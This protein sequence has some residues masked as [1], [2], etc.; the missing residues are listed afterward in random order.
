MSR[1]TVFD[2]ADPQ[3]AAPIPKPHE[4][5]AIVIVSFGGPDSSSDVLPFLENVLRGRNVPR[6]RMLEVAEHY[7]KLGGRSPINDQNRALIAA[8]EKEFSTHGIKMPV[9]WG[10]RNW[11]PLLHDTLR[12][13]TADGVQRAL[14]F[15]T[16]AYGSYSSCRQYR[17]DIAAAR[18]EVGPDAPIIDKLRAFFN[19]P[20]FIE[21]MIERTQAA[22]HRIP[23]SRRGN[24]ELIFTA[25]SIP[26]EMAQTSPYESQL[27]LASR[28]VANG[29]GH[30]NWRLVYQ[31]RS[32]PPQQPWLEPDICDYLTKGQAGS[33][34]QDIVVV[35]IGFISDHMEVL[36]DLDTEAR[37]L[38]ERLGINMVRAGT[39]GTHPRFVRMIRELV[40]E[41]TSESPQRLAL[42]E[43][44]PSHD[45]CPEDCCAYRPT[46]N[47]PTANPVDEVAADRPRP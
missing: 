35:P 30:D 45:V 12:Q 15:V 20:G 13:M 46:G 3:S 23:D 1:A 22:L 42:G 16:S 26:R 24:A 32:G 41:R 31:S 21:P 29:V 7:Y 33:P 34:T 19:H 10:N 39:V 5:D 47:N 28:L 43:L 11:H 6:K 14:A 27:L 2:S 44:G 40:E 18:A 9:Y 38:C 37:Q 25:H 36:Y 8:V 4:Y 17:E